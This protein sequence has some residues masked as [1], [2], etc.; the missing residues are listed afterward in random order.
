MLVCQP[1][2][3]NFGALQ[4]LTPR[5]AELFYRKLRAAVQPYDAKP[6]TFPEAENDPHWY[7][8]STHPTAKAWLAYDRA[9]D[10]FYPRV[11]PRAELAV[12]SGLRAR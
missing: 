12:S 3:A 6:L 5:S 9:L 1:L 4:G 7:V 11:V 2:N 10:T 8:D